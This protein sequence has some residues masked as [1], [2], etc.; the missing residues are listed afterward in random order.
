MAQTKKKTPQNRK[1]GLEV[2]QEQENFTLSD[3]EQ[4]KVIIYSVIALSFINSFTLIMRYLF[5]IA[6]LQSRIVSNSPFYISVSSILSIGAWLISTTTDYWNYRRRKRVYYTITV[7]S[8]Y[9]TILQPI[10]TFLWKKI[11]PWTLSWEINEAMTKELVLFASYS[12]I[13][14]SFA[15]ICALCILPFRSMFFS[16]E[17]YERISRF[18]LGKAID[19][20][21]NRRY[22]Y[23]QE[24]VWNLETAAPI[25]FKEQDRFIQTFLDGAS[26]SGKT[27]SVIITMILGDLNKKLLNAQIRIK[28]YSKYLKSGIFGVKNNGKSFTEK[29]I[30]VKKGPLS[31]YYEKKLQ[32]IQK[33]YGDCGMTVMAPN[34]DLIEQVI[35]AAVARGQQINVIDPV[36]DWS[37]MSPLVKMCGIAQFYVEPGLSFD[38]TADRINKNAAIFSDV[39]VAASEVYERVEKY[40]KDINTSISTNV[41]IITMLYYHL[42]GQQADIN[43]VRDAINNF[44]ICEQY[45]NFIESELHIHVN[46]PQSKKP[47]QIDSI[48][49]TIKEENPAIRQNPYYQAIYFVKNELLGDGAEDILKQAR[50]LR[51]LINS[52]LQER[53]VRKVLSADE[54]NFINMDR[55]FSE[56]QI[57]V[58]NTALENGAVSS[59]TFGLT[60]L[61]LHKAAVIRRPMNTR[62]NHFVYID[63]ASQYLHPCIED[64][65]TLYRQ[66][67]VAVLL[68]FQNL[69]QMSKSNLTLYLKNIVLGAGIHIV[70]GRGGEEEMKIYSEM[71]G[72]KS[73]DIIQ[74][75]VSRNSILAENA[76]KSFSRRITKGTTEK[77]TKQDI[78]NRDFQEVMIFLTDQGNV[79]DGQLGKVSFAKKSE[80]KKKKVHRLLYELYADDPCGD[81]GKHPEQAPSVFQRRQSIEEAFSHLNFGV[82]NY[83]REVSKG[84]EYIFLNKPLKNILEE[85]QEE[86]EE[87]FIFLQP[88][89]DPEPESSNKTNSLYTSNID[90]RNSTALSSEKE[91]DKMH[92]ENTEKT[93]E[94]PTA[95][96]KINLG[97]AFL[98]MYQK[99]EEKI[100]EEHG[101]EDINVTL[102]PAAMEERTL[103]RKDIESFLKKEKSKQEEQKTIKNQISR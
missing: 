38:D 58:V 3:L 62:S 11:M 68:A 56:N 89:F 59:T 23:D 84:E 96:P 70:F 22:L 1:Q 54:N 87:H 10:Y 49:S 39:L 41:S 40:F 93:E 71:C 65:Y 86:D 78:R 83:E 20:R 31:W 4:N 76:T 35:K 75:T 37:F 64:F 97:K 99:E 9:A 73:Q 42:K 14:L 61:M 69:A 19:L 13:V 82:T 34:N 50:G 102:I 8:V 36:K 28:K 44:A 46:V 67:R 26:G 88:D 103:S 32:K 52:L 51:L 7:I 55:L 74:D 91:K 98:Q 57:T 29:D 6:N 79:I 92:T 77:Y 48:N 47:L 85:Q 24:V 15:A 21:P 80:F 53:G 17:V 12:L 63:E 2:V 100:K 72:L 30:Y 43:A 27:S 45:I 16:E 101:A 18:K 60:F 81:L 66:Y 94:P 5:A 95:L 33:K 90:D 25:K